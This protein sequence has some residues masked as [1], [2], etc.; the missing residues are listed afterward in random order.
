MSNW[1]FNAKN[2]GVMCFATKE[3]AQKEY[4]FFK[5]INVQ[6]GKI[7]LGRRR[8]IDCTYG[9]QLRY[10]TSTQYSYLDKNGKKVFVHGRHSPDVELD[11]INMKIFEGG[12]VN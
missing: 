6:V 10:Q 8:K 2:V 5:S 1:S 12:I 9:F 11:N 3:Q 7:R 4:D